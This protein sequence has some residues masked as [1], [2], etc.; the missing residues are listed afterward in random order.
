MDFEKPISPLAPGKSFG[1]FEGRVLRERVESEL[2]RWD[3]QLSTMQELTFQLVDYPG[4]YSF[5]ILT[6][7]FFTI[8]LTLPGRL[9]RS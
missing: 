6:W 7:S 2:F 3:S 5:L 8:L 4:S 1:K 9:P